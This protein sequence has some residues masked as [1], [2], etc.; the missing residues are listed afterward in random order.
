MGRGVGVDVESRCWFH[1]Q[2]GASYM[3]SLA[4]AVGS[5]GARSPSTAVPVQGS[6]LV[7]EADIV[8][9]QARSAIV[10]SLGIRNWVGEVREGRC[11]RRHYPG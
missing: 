6:F 3:T 2:Q 10:V 4:S 11:G 8:G 7:L 1:E 5:A 9:G